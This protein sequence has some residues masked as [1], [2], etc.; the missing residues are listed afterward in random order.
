MELVGDVAYEGDD[1]V[2]FDVDAGE[3]DDD[4]DDDGSVELF[5]RSSLSRILRSSKRDNDDMLGSFLSLIESVFRFK[6]GEL[7]FTLLLPLA[8]LALFKLQLLELEL[9]A[10]SFRRLRIEVGDD[11]DDMVP[12][13]I[14]ALDGDLCGTL[15][16]I[17]AASGT[18]RYLDAVN[19]AC[20]GFSKSLRKFLF[21]DE[22]LRP[23]GDV[24]SV[25]GARVVFDGDSDEDACVPETCVDVGEVGGD[26]F[27]PPA[28]VV[29]VVVKPA[30]T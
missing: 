2:L 21:N 26:C 14:D 18:S 22:K 27:L 25:N 7:D 29:V 10:A 17:D 13:S 5:V 4:D 19:D 8:L 16:D 23:V 24:T 3:D 12:N 30:R 20:D 9:A 6:T 28:A 15:N 1:V 11:D